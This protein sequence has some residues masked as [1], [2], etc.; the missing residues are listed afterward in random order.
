MALE[1]EHING[2]G[3]IDKKKLRANSIRDIYYLKRP[4]LAK[5]T[6]QLLCGS[7]HNVKTYINKEWNNIHA[8]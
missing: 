2:D 8:R 5:K 6:L 3:Y 4:R 1:I 7:C